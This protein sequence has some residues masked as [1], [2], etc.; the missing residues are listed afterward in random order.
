M[1]TR[2]LLWMLVGLLF[3]YVAYQLYRVFASGRAAPGSAATTAPAPDAFQTEL[4]VQQLRRDLAQ[5]RGELA[6][7]QRA[8]AEL[9]ARVGKLE[10]A[11][12]PAPAPAAPAALALG[13]GVSPEYS[14]AL[15]FARRG[16]GVEAIAERCGITVAEAELV[17]ALA[18]REGSPGG[19]A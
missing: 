15:V 13:P 3:A 1:G 12:A 2:E 9:G 7:Q 6:T 19:G 10:Q 17:C 16:L 18:R 14:E 8:L 4:E 11:P 5:L